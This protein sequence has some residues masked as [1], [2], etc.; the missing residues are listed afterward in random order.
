MARHLVDVRCFPGP[1]ERVALHSVAGRLRPPLLSGGV[2][3]GR[4]KNPSGTSSGA[5]G[6]RDFVRP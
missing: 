5:L 6:R 2:D 4:P 3:R 1:G